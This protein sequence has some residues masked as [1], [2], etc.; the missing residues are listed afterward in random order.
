MSVP[1][2]RKTSS[3]TK[4]GRSHQALKMKQLIS[5]PNCKEMIKAHRACPNC[6]QYK[7]KV[8]LKTQSD[9]KAAQV[10]KKDA[11]AKAAQKKAS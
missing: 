10:A 2:R 8:V 1:K 9:K 6:G 3:K 7:A 4:M 5:C 11:K